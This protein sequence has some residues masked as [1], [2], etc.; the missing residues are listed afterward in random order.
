MRGRRDRL[1]LAGFFGFTTIAFV[2]AG[3]AQSELVIT[4]E[5]TREY[6]WPGCNEIKDSK[7]VLALTRAQ[8]AARGLKPHEEC[9]PAN[10]A[11]GKPPQPEAPT[12]V[13]TDS[14]RYYHKKDCKK[15]G[16]DA[17]K[18]ELEQAGRKYWP[19]PECKPPI[20]KRKSAALAAQQ[21][22][23]NTQRDR[24]HRNPHGKLADRAGHVCTPRPL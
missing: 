7:K 24:G 14:S 3:V 16:K 10:A 2:P 15:L 1:I 8:A 4:K 19:C 12:M 20:R 22:R 18:V 9:D 5:G 17:K 13:Y 21:Q 11:D 6:H 23:Q